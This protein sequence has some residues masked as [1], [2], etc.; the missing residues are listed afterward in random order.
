MVNHVFPD[1]TETSSDIGRLAESQAADFLEKKGL[2]LKQKNYR[3]QGGEIDLVM[4][5]GHYL[6]FVEVKMRGN[7]NYGHTLELVEKPKRFRIIH[8]AKWYLLEHKL[9][10]TAFCRFDVVGISPDQHNPAKQKIT[11]I[12]NAFEVEYA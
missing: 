4:Q 12:K 7:L 5:D 9:Y 6:V 3:T 10:D 2:I 8:A 11:W 1:D